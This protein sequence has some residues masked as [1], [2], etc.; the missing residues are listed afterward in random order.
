MN[1]R[2]QSLNPYCSGQWSHTDGKEVI[3]KATK[4]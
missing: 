4:S 2:I 3:M 1:P